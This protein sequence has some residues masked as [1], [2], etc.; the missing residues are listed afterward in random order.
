MR[1]MRYVQRAR[2][3][4]GPG[5]A[6]TIL[7]YHSIDPVPH[8]FAITPDTFERQ[9]D[10]IQ[11]RYEI[12]RLRDVP[13]LLRAGDAK[14]RVVLTFDDAYVDFARHA[15]PRLAERSIPA[16]VFV[17]TAFIGGVNAWDQHIDGVPLRHI[18]TGQ[19]LRAIQAT[20]LV[21]LG[22]HT[23]D[24]VRMSRIEEGEMRRQAQGSRATLEHLLQVPVRSF[25]YPYGM[26]DD[27]SP[28]AER[29]L[30]EAGYDVAV[31]SHWGTV[32]SAANLLSLRRIALAERDD[33]ETITAKIEGA[34]DW[35]AIKERVAT[36]LRSA[37]RLTGGLR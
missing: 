24:H 12:V 23:I 21:D 17:P 37:R 19:E 4:L 34:Y 3:T 5:R 10:L 36:V 35:I 18:M 29:V 28:T 14:R 27:C 25:A 6:L 30:A 15:L 1:G 13:A 16:T 11:S 26:L 8:R 2:R 20:G 33:D 9:L 32:N 22:S 7:E 31:V